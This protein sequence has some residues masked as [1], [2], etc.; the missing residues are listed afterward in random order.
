M[1][2]VLHIYCR[3]SSDIQEEEGVS[4]DV[5]KEGGIKRSE[6][7]GFKYKIWNEGSKSSKYD[8][9]L[10][11][12]VLGKLLDEMDNGNIL[13]LYSH[14]QSRLSRNENVFN[15]ITSLCTRQFHEWYK[16]R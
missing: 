2:E 9:I 5:Q 14:E 16:C 10:N 3:V 7:L 11:R 13:H 6:G 4:L 15:N 8:D 12:P 1:K